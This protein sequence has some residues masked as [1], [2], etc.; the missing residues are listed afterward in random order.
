MIQ[1]NF[2]SPS[3]RQEIHR[4]IRD[5]AREIGEDDN[6]DLLE[7]LF[8]LETGQDGHQNNGFGWV[9]NNSPTNSTVSFAM[10]RGAFRTNLERLRAATAADLGAAPDGQ[11]DA[12]AE[13]LTVVANTLE[14]VA[15]AIET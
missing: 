4:Y 2:D 9:Q 1:C 6:V 11:L 12:L 14:S 15:T 8:T 7:A 10:S 13:N 5:A 3:Q